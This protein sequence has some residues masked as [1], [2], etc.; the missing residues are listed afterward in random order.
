MPRQGGSLRTGRKTTPVAAAT[1]LAAFLCL[2][3]WLL[4]PPAIAAPAWLNPVD[5][6]AAGEDAES[7][8]VAVDPASNMVAVWVRSDGAKDIVQAATRPAGG[9]WGPAIPLSA[10]GQNAEAPRVAVD[11]SGN[12]VAVWTRFNGSRKVVQSAMRPAGGPWGPVDELSDAGQNAVTPAVAVDPAGNAAA[13]WSRYNGTNDIVQAAVR[14]AGG[15]WEEAED[16]SVEGRDA[17]EPEVAIDSAGAAFAVWRRH[18]GTR[19]VIQAAIRPLG[20][21][22]QEPE[23]LSE[24]GQAAEEPAVTV[25]PAGDAAAV[26][27]RYDGAKEIAQAA[28]RPAGGAWQEPDDLS[29]AGQNAAEPDVAIDPA[30]DTVAVWTRQGSPSTV[31]QGS[32]FPAGG[33]WEAPATL[34]IPGESTEA[35]HVAVDPAGTAIAVWS[36]TDGTPKVI[37][38]SIRPAGGS[39]S[40]AGRLSELGRNATEPQVGFDPSGDAVAVWTRDNGSNTVVQGIGYDSVAPLLRGL[41]IPTAGTVRQP[42][43]FS[44][45]PFDAWSPIGPVRWAFGDGAGE[46]GS[47]VGHAF[48]ATGTYL[49]SVT[50]ADALGN[51]RS[52][53]GV[54]TIYPKARAGRNVRVRGRRALLRLFCPSPAGCDGRLKLIVGHKFK[55]NGRRVGRRLPV[56]STD[57]AVPGQ[58]STA[59]QVRLSKK[60]A[61]I[62]REAGRRGVKAQL[63]GPGVKHRIVVLFASRR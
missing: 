10:P 27:V 5:L 28:V 23:R 37:Q 54:V 58:V 20:G 34:S 60:G 12:A 7:P 63:T 55:R 11:S 6:S 43:T 21:D 13:V 59:V 3:G 2:L 29:A 18:D 39:W 57:F 40:P 49:V 17:L 30:G 32:R 41:A 61:E 52:A 47:T 36:A 51:G 24:T 46:A 48:S 42:L 15:A 50:A 1:L 35:P 22:W 62:V 8:Q 44:V 33:A 45:A 56:G 26:W 19:Y 25:N 16:V 14:A 53:T 9:S 31:V 4:A 38:T